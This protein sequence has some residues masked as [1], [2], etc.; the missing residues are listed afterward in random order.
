MRYYR[1]VLGKGSG[2]R[3]FTSF[4]NGKSIPGALNVELDIPVIPF[5]TPMGAGAITIWGVPL[6]DISQASDFNGMDISVYGGMQKGLP[7]ANPAQSGL[8][9]QGKVFQAFGNWIDTEQTLNFN[10]QASIGTIDEPKNIILN[11]KKK[12]KLSEAIQNTLSTA[13]PD[14]KLDIKISDKL[15]LPADEI[16]YFQTLVQFA[17]YIRVVSQT[18][19]GGDYPGVDIVL[20]ESTLKIYDGTTQASPL[21]I[22][23]QDMIGQP[24]WIDPLTVQTKFVMRADIN[25]GDYLK[26]PPA[27]VTNTS[28]GAATAGSNL[29]QKSTFQGTFQANLVRHIGNFRQP[30]AASWVTVVNAAATQPVTG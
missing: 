28:A 2:G 14:F 15:V 24:T 11:W 9:A 23:F 7:L 25:V 4:V 16:G 3:E 20:T 8:L 30:D 21:Q 5:A 26:F 29:K 12:A 17:Q 13:F 27:L 22:A 1:I 18:I 6:S 10:I 19:L